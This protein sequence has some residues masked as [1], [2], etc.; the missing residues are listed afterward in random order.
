M[1]REMNDFNLCS[2]G[3]T[4]TGKGR[5]VMISTLLV[6]ASQLPVLCFAGKADYHDVD[7]F[8]TAIDALDG[9]ALG[10]MTVHFIGT[11]VEGRPIRAL[12]LAAL[13][14]GGEQFPDNPRKPALLIEGGIHAREWASA[15]LC[16]LFLQAFHLAVLFDPVR[17][18]DILANADIWVIPM[19]NPD[20]RAMDDAAHGDPENFWSS[21][22]YHDNDDS[23]LSGWRDNTSVVACGHFSSG[24]TKGID[25]NRSFSA[26]WDDPASGADEWLCNDNNYHGEVPF[27]AREANVLRKFVNNRMIS[28]SLH[29]HAYKGCVGNRN[30]YVDIAANFH[31]VWNAAVP[32]ELTLTLTSSSSPCTGG[33]YGQSTAWMADPSDTPFGQFLDHIQ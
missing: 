15:E 7:E 26:G 25:L 22:L 31:D 5:I 32:S 28:M 17:I 29:V 24:F 3:R 23:D 33:G 10:R 13:G 21:K 14:P 30:G 11:S 27:Q 2:A 16:L 19:L 20:G 12:H 8:N 9:G 1:N 6:L 4:S 18:D